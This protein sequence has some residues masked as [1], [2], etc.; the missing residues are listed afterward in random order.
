MVVGYDEHGLP[1]TKNVLAKTKQDCQEK[2]DALKE[3]LGAP[4]QTEKKC[5]PEMPFG[6]WL[7]HWYRTYVRPNIRPGTRENYELRI[8]K[9]ITPTSSARG[10]PTGCSAPAMRSSKRRCKRRWT[11]RS[12]ATTSPSAASCRP[13]A[14]RR[15]RC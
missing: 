9:H 4:V 15:C 11:N 6:D 12:C 10:S 7:D 1:K 13:N 14:P 3:P 8:Y 5:S 2:L